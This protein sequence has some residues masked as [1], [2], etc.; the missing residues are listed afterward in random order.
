GRVQPADRHLSKGSARGTCAILD[1]RG[2]FRRGQYK[3]AADAFLKGYKKYKSGDKAPEILKLGMSLAAL[4][5]KEAACS[6]FGE[7]KTKFP[8][9]P[10]TVRDEA[11]A[12]QKKTRC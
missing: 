1:R 7:L 9:A 5:Q 12:E 4:A 8:K 6:T 11:K 10:E 3:N 2:L